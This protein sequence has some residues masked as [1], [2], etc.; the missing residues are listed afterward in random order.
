MISCLKIS[1]KF[2]LWLWISDKIN[3]NPIFLLYWINSLFWVCWSLHFIIFVYCWKNC[4]KKSYY[5][6]NIMPFP[7][8]NQLQETRFILASYRGI[9]N[10]PSSSTYC[11]IFSSDKR[12]FTYWTQKKRSCCLKQAQIFQ[13][14]TQNIPVLWLMAE[15]EMKNSEFNLLEQSHP[16]YT[17]LQSSLEKLL[18]S[19]CQHL[20]VLPAEGLKFNIFKELFLCKVPN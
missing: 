7:L 11:T 6:L 5:K 1:A 12:L 14:S 4:I 15:A 3:W 20:S 9:S 17:K 19:L 2:E 13:C 8:M 18:W 16:Q 10:P